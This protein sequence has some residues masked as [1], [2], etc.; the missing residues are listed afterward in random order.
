MVCRTASVVLPS[1]G[2]AGMNMRMMCRGSSADQLCHCTGRDGSNEQVCSSRILCAPGGCLDV[3]G[4]VRLLPEVMRG[5]VH[6]TGQQKIHAP[7]GPRLTSVLRL[8]MCRSS[9]SFRRPLRC[10]CACVLSAVSVSFSSTTELRHFPLSSW[11]R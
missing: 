6:A 7:T 10:L 8:R 2:V 9:I 4:Q 1:A 3:P 11:C 5:S